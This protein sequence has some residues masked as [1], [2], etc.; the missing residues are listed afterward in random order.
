MPPRTTSSLRGASCIAP[1]EI[2]RTAR[3]G[4]IVAAVRG[5]CMMAPAIASALRSCRKRC[6][7]ET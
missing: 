6:S 1:S 5:T 3:Y 4:T 2:L 7:R